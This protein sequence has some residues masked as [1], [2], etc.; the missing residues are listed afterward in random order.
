MPLNSPGILIIGLDGGSF[1]LIRPWVKE[2]KLPHLKRLINEGIATNL[3][4]TVPP[5]TFPAWNAFMTGR[6]PGKHGVYDFMERRSGTYELEIKNAL[7][8]KCETIWHIVSQYGKKCTSIGVPVTYPPEKINGVMISGF[9]TPYLDERIMFPPELFSELKEKVGR[10]IVTADYEKHL[11]AGNLNSAVQELLRAVDQKAETARYILQKELWDLFMIVFGE[12]DVALHHFWKHHDPDSPQR[13]ADT[14]PD[15]DP[16]L[17]I[18]ERV[19]HQ[20]GELL[21]SVSADTT[22]MIMSDHGAGGAG[23]KSIYLNRFLELE[24]LLSF[25]KISLSRQLNE[26]MDRMKAFIRFMMPQKLKKKLRFRAKGLGLK[27]ESG[28][29][30]SLIDWSRTTIYA[31]ETPYYPNLRV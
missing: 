4:S 6:N 23:D 26:V 7:D 19:D 16:I 8:R 3:K 30:F 9:D 5:M 2:G 13:S 1:N 15:N 29:R 18:Y 28:L 14:D 11:R 17:R 22:V 25:K 27:M 12:T 20:L 24:G 31:E 21:K 10:Y